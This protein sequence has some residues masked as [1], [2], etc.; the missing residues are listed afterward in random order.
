[1]FKPQRLT[2]PEPEPLLSKRLG[3]EIPF[4]GI[5]LKDADTA[6]GEGQSPYIKN[7]TLDDGGKPTKRRGQAWL[8]EVDIPDAPIRGYYNELFQ[9]KHVFA[10]SSKLYSYDETTGVITELMSGLSDKEG[11][12]YVFNDFLYYK[13]R[14]EFIS[15]SNTF[16]VKNVITD[17]LG[18]I[19]TTVINKKP[20]GEGGTAFEERNLIQPGFTETFKGETG[21]TT[22]Y[23]TLDDLDD[24]PVKAK[25]IIDNA[26]VDY[27]ENIDFTVDRTI[28][29]VTFNTAPA[30][31]DDKAN[32]SITAYKTEGYADRIIKAV[33][34]ALYGGGTNDSRIFCCGNEE[35]K[36]VYWYTGLTG[37]TNND[38]L[39][40][41][42]FGFNRIG[43]DA[44]MISGWSYLYSLL[45]ALKED[46]IY[47]ITYQSGGTFPAAIL[48][49]QVGCDMPG[50]IQI[51]K[52]Y[53]VFGNT[54]SGLWTIVNVIASDTEKNV[55]PLSSLI[56]KPPVQ[57][58]DIKGLLEETAEDLKAASSFD[59]GKKY[60]LCIGD[61]AWVW[62]YDRR[63][64]SAATGQANLI[65]YYFTN[66]HAANW[67]YSGREMY[68]AHRTTGNLVKFQ[69]NLNDFG[70]AIDGR[71]KTKLFNFD[72]PERLKDIPDVWFT[73]RANSNTTIEVIYYNDNGEQMDNSSVP[74][75]GLKSF[76]WDDWDWDD[77][78][79]DVQRYAPTIKLRP[80]IKK[81]Q[82]FSMEF[83][84]N[85]INENLSIL[86]LVIFY[87]LSTFVK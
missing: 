12:F 55:E 58:S 72:R 87:K 26:W 84:N 75:S 86:N 65:W 37:N 30:A 52:N 24:T 31:S 41:P 76:D 42:E 18:Y 85:V 57:V 71:F 36:N 17:G 10:G 80:K 23:L 77:F 69:D 20:N 82:Y 7:V 68:Y 46:G 13:N 67:H 27:V 5:N 74:V 21:V 33:R 64:Y 19:P 47:K 83:R 61:H 15:I 49:R 11:F 16:E 40:Y 34:V 81:V 45:I 51:I 3:D 2:L 43:S 6:I 14:A 9:G 50:S 25:V 32:V 44:K 35:F 1:M 38:A 70:E 78:T 22:Y 60:Y 28:G 62:D 4:S 79:W 66:I 73:T 54:Q 59:D 39:Y 56:N 53:P 63:P 48:N 29:K 8:M